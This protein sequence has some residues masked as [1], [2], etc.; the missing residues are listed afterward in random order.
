LLNC[1]RLEQI[2]VQIRKKNVLHLLSLIK[3]LSSQLEQYH[4]IQQLSLK[5]KIKESILLDELERIKTSPA[6]SSNL[7]SKEKIPRIDLICQDLFSLA[8]SNKQFLP[9]L[10]EHQEFLP[11][12]WQ[13]ILNGNNNQEINLLELRGDYK[14]Q[15][16][17]QNELEKLFQELINQLKI[18]FYKNQGEKLKSKIELAQQNG[19][20][21]E[22]NKLLK[23][24]QA[25]Y[26]KINLIK[27]EL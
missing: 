22:L 9:S 20:L 15:N 5:T 8:F 13:E 18:E 6:L 1:H 21:N 2:L 19:N 17:D 24:F 14:F 3:Q 12:K 4:I 16:I 10:K 25:T 7:V 27:K 26:Q 11:P 23:E